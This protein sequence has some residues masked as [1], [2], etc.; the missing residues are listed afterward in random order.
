MLQQNRANIAKSSPFSALVKA[1][2][3]G[4]QHVLV[5]ITFIL[6]FS[7]MQVSMA[8]EENK[9]TLILHAVQ[10]GESQ[11]ISLS[12]SIVKTDIDMRITGMINRVQV[13]QIFK[14]PT[15]KWLNGTYLF[16]LPNAAVIDSMRIQLG[17][18]IF[19][20]KVIEQ[21]LAKKKFQQA[22]KSTQRISLLEQH[23]PNLFTTSLSNIGPGEQIRIEFSYQHM[24]QYD[25]G[26]FKLRMPMAVIPR[27]IS[28]DVHSEHA[29]TNISKLASRSSA[30]SLAARN[31][32]RP[33]NL[34]PLSLHIELDAGFPVTELDSRYH[35]IKK[36]NH[37]LGRY[38]IRFKHKVVKTERDFELF[39]R[40][41]PGRLP[42]T[43]MFHEKVDDEHYYFVMLY[44]P[45]PKSNNT[46]IKK[47]VVFVVDTSGSMAGTSIR[48][49]RNA[50]L[51]AL[52]DL[53]PEDTF[54]VI[55]FNSQTQ[56]LFEQAKPASI[57]NISR[58]RQFVASINARGGTEML[59]ALKKAL[60][61]NDS[62]HRLRQ[63]IYL[64]DG[65]IINEQALF[66]TIRKDIKQSRLF[67]VGIGSSPNRY[68]LKKAAEIGRGTYTYISNASEV[69]TGLKKLFK[70]ISRP[71]FLDLSIV[72][73]PHQDETRRIS[74]PDLYAGDPL[75][76]ALKTNGKY[77]QVNIVGYRAGKKWGSQ[78]I[79]SESSNGFGVA[80]YWA[81]EKI[82]SYM[83]T[84]PSSETHH[85]IQK[86]ITE[87]ALKH[88]IASPYTSLLATDKSPT[89][90]AKV[91]S[92]NPV[93]VYSDVIQVAHVSNIKVN[94]VIPLFAKTA[95]DAEGKFILGII[96]LL[97]ALM[98]SLYLSRR[99]VKETG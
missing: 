58:A 32:P 24:V 28:G 86:A 7:F 40:L 23:R 88:Q 12:A 68:F 79:L 70:K 8:A 87:L 37:G 22:K 47:E 95:T 42:R 6:F 85:E 41:E 20:A 93:Q 69:E 55:T 74:I 96:S 89:L 10:K 90:T 62:E 83:D 5:L 31:D 35:A 57:F 56:S 14:N 15:T 38:S 77:G 9:N 92:D 50:L 81:N 60:E 36:T 16:P 99:Y 61:M 4:V 46:V 33:K 19:K 67:T 21:A 30:L 27:Y 80:K 17:E 49:T 29:E 1:L 53:D 51:S 13:V 75:S 76:F 78:L 64:T 44:P 94:Q 11:P 3:N 45:E 72:Y 84:L 97:L 25:Q 43:A 39:W 48:Q 65:A 82:R 54:N 91:S 34:A 73:H 26:E 2:L 52:K 71:L 66:D 98:L 59:P 18:R 63:I